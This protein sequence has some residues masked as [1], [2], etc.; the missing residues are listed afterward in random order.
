M[1]GQL[2]FTWVMTMTL[3]PK[4]SQEL[5]MQLR[6]QRLVHW[7]IL[8][9]VTGEQRAVAMH[10]QRSTRPGGAAMFESWCVVHNDDAMQMATRQGASQMKK[11]ECNCSCPMVGICA[12]DG[13]L[14]S[15]GDNKGSQARGFLG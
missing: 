4:T 13:S 6:H 7:D 14:V 3:P 2:E 1:L 5:E 11:I 9:S 12:V 10:N 15:N 8:V